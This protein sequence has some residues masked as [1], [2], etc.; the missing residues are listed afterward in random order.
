MSNIVYSSEKGALCP[1]CGKPID[2]C[3]CHSKPS[4]GIAKVRREKKA[5]GGKIVTT[6][7]GLPLTSEELKSLT[8]ELKR[9]FGTGGA[10]KERVIEIQGDRADDIMAELK[11]R[12]YAAKR[13]GG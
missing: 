6:I 8:S 12:G 11:K 5:R 1:E 13:S 4:S 2:D 10:L 9:K 3:I 7:T